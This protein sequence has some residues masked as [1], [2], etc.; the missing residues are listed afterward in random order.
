MN[1]NGFFFLFFLIKAHIYVFKVRVIKRRHV[2]V[3]NFYLL[4]LLNILFK[5][6]KFFHIFC[7]KIVKRRIQNCYS[8]AV[9][10]SPYIA[11]YPV[12][13]CNANCWRCICQFLIYD[14]WAKNPNE[15]QS[16]T[17]PQKEGWT[18]GPNMLFSSIKHDDIWYIQMAP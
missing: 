18:I 15:V 3:I 1:T 12:L 7:W 4:H 11:Q 16:I 6:V 9:G 13:G 17:L 5:I 14:Q 10:D 2:N 8:A